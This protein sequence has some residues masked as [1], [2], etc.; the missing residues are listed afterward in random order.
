MGGG[1]RQRRDKNARDRRAALKRALVFSA[2][3]HYRDAEA[4]LREALKAARNS[5]HVL[6]TERCELWNELGM[7]CKYLGKF[8]SAERYYRLALR[9]ADD[10]ETGPRREQL[11]AD[12][13]H[14]LGGIEHS[15]R[16][17]RRAERYA[18]KGLQIR[19]RCVAAGDLTVASDRAA[20][21]AILD[22]LQRYGE[23]KK[24]YNQ[25]L[26][27]Y[28]REY[29]PSHF[30]IAVILNN[31]GVL[32]AAIGRP[33]RAYLY[34]RSALEMKRR[35][36]GGSHPDVAVT[37]NNLATLQ[38]AQGRPD[39][40]RIWFA[41]AIRLLDSSWGGAHPISRAVRRNQQIRGIRQSAYSREGARP[42]LV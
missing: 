8:D 38:A 21:A 1:A 30:E 34:Y 28:C 40:A 7:V 32:Y 16:H 4:C 27:T 37:M 5:A 10:L 17:F 31:L 20:L 25:A 39:L 11:L 26:R 15:R 29:G 36:V 41:K 33:K 9:R 13:Y 42:H 6:A 14:N 3:G 19:L 18:R 2:R 35:E 12:L 23:S 22:G 24:L